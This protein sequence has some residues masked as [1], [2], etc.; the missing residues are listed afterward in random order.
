[1]FFINYRHGCTRRCPR[2]SLSP[3]SCTDSA[4]S[5]PGDPSETSPL[6]IP[7][8]PATQCSGR[9][10][11]HQKEVGFKQKTAFSHGCWTAAQQT[12]TCVRLEPS[13]S[14][15]KVA[16]WALWGLT[17]TSFISLLH[18]GSWA[19]SGAGVCGEG[20]LAGPRRCLSRG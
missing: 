2:E 11:P 1:M 8:C 12:P 3:G 16:G 13:Y 20:G 14:R 5:I 10:Q 15:V 9:D 6:G 17:W 19:S 18:P 4:V 7:S